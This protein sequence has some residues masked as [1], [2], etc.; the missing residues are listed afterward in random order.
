[1]AN[2]HIRRSM[3]LFPIGTVMELTELTARQIR[4]YEANGLVAPARTKGNRRL[5]SF[6]D[7]DRLLDIKD[8]LDQGINMAGIKEIFQ[9]QE[10]IAHGSQKAVSAKKADTDI[11]NEEIRKMLRKEFLHAG[12]FHRDGDNTRFYH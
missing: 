7:I 4:Y 6:N 9:L 8:R 12:R 10:S 11:T 2:G 3:P 1:M 5:Y